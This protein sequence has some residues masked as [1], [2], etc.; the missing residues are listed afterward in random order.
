[1]VYTNV[2]IA[3]TAQSFQQGF[4][5]IRLKKYSFKM[6]IAKTRSWFLKRKHITMKL[7]L[8]TK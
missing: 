5:N 7:L 2:K 4:Y 3:K 6:Y 1:M 8:T